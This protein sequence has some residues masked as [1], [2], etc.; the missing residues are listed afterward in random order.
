MLGSL[1]IGGSCGE[2]RGTFCAEGRTGKGGKAGQGEDQTQEV[3]WIGGGSASHIL[4]IYALRPG[5]SIPAPQRCA[6]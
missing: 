1:G 3:G 2:E 5:I 4:L 6:S